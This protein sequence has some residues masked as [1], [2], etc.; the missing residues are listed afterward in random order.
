[1][2]RGDG[3]ET[4]VKHETLRKHNVSLELIFAYNIKH[5]I[6]FESFIFRVLKQDL[7]KMK[8]AMCFYLIAILIFST[9][10]FY[11]LFDESQINALLNGVSF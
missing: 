8:I 11:S 9:K 2:A 3:R 6:K 4:S 7:A 5:N 1:V 10:H